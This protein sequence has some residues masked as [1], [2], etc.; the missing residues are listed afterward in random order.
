MLLQRC[1]Q[2]YWWAQLCPVM[3]QSELV[4]R[5]SVQHGG[6]LWSLLTE[7]TPAASPLLKPCHVH[8]PSAL[9]QTEN[10][11][12]L[13]WFSCKTK[14][15]KLETNFLLLDAVIMESSQFN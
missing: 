9:F 4:E 10:N 6:S 13:I 12:L 8:L 3:G 2:S 11:F 15:I 5:V 14:Q 1:H 7:D